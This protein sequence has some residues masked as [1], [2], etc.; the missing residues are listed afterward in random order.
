MSEPK[1]PA[2]AITKLAKPPAAVCRRHSSLTPSLP[3]S[4][5][6]ATCVSL[7]SPSHPPV[8]ASQEKRVN[9]GDQPVPQSSRPLALHKILAGA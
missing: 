1:T 3:A 9:A 4:L 6:P 5:K 7:P 8:G 2:G